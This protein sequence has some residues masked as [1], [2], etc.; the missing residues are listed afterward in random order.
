[1]PIYEYFCADCGPFSALRQMA[2]FQTPQPCETC[3]KPAPRALLTAPALSG[4]N[5]G[6]RRAGEVNERSA[7]AP[8]RAKRHSTSC[9]CCA[10]VRQGRLSAETVAA[11]GFPNQRPWMISH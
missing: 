2:E 11:K 6:R 1:M 4:M 8:T 7:N 3:G 9:G 10:G 5:P